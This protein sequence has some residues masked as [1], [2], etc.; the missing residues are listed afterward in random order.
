MKYL[1]LLALILMAC[2]LKED[3]KKSIKDDN[4]YIMDCRTNPPICFSVVG[5]NNMLSHATVNCEQ[6]KHLLVNKCN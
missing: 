5:A 1:L 3:Q 6:V 2:S 4:N